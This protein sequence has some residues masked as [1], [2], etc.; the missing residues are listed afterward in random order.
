MNIDELLGQYEVIKAKGFKV[1]EDDIFELVQIWDQLLD[2]KSELKSECAIME[3]KLDLEKA[4]YWLLLKETT[5]QEESTWKIKTYTDKVISDKKLI[6]YNSENLDIKLKKIV[7]DRINDKLKTIET[8]H[9]DI[10]KLI[11][12]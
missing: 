7:I 10:K 5:Y 6:K 9:N 2:I 11:Y 8:T 1:V 4:E 12:K 3:N